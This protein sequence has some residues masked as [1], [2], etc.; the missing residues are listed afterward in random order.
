[1]ISYALVDLKAPT[2]RVSSLSMGSWQLTL[3]SPI[4]H[5]I[6][7]IDVTRPRYEGYHI[8][9]LPDIIVVYRL[10]RKISAD[11]VS[12]RDRVRIARS[13]LRKRTTGIRKVYVR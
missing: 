13:H 11:L 2:K 9:Y 3:L 8:I 12:L 5:L 10:E 1:M 7:V 4:I 6:E